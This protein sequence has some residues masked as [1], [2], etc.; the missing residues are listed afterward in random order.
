MKLTNPSLT[1]LLYFEIYFIKDTIFLRK[2]YKYFN[3]YSY[4]IS[5]AFILKP[6]SDIG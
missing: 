2:I 5:V 1:R 3:K 4:E 6:F